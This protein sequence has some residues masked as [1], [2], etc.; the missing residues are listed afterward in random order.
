MAEH[1]DNPACA[2][3]HRIMDPIG[4]SLENFD[5]VGAWRDREAAGIMIDASGTHRVTITTV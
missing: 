2:S 1:R 4:L 5:A 3:C